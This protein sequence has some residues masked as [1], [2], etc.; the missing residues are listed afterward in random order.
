[1]LDFMFETLIDFEEFCKKADAFVERQKKYL[2]EGEENGKTLTKTFTVN[3]VDTAPSKVGDVFQ[4][5]FLPSDSATMLPCSSVRN[6]FAPKLL[7]SFIGS[8]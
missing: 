1:M 7:N 2:K 4:V 3:V 5:R 6:N 8:A